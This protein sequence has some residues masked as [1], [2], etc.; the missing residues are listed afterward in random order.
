[1]I[2]IGAGDLRLLRVPDHVP[3]EGLFRACSLDDAAIGIF[4]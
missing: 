3:F 1:M 4:T 2:C